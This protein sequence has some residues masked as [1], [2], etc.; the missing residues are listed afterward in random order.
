MQNPPVQT[1]SGGEVSA[2]TALGLDA[3]L[4]AALGYPVGILAIIIFVMEKENRFARFHALQSILYHVAAVVIFIALGV[5]MAILMVVLGLISNSL[6]A[7]VGVLLWLVFV[8]V[9]LV[10]FAGLLFL[11]FK[12]YGGASMHVPVVGGMT[13]KILNK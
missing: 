13:D 5:V 6:A 9:G 8:V 2:K 11:A 10:Y 12:A 1:G 7:I 4:G 3:N